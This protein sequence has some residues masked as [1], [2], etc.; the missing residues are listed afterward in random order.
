MRLQIA[1]WMAILLFWTTP[2]LADGRGAA[3]LSVFSSNDGLT[4]VSPQA[5][6][7]AEIRDWLSADANYEADIISAASVDLITAASPRGYREERHG[8]GAGVTIRPAEA[9]VLSVHYGPSFEPDYVSHGASVSAEREWFDRRLTTQI[10]YRFSI[11]RIGRRG[12]A[13]STWRDLQNHSLAASLGWVFSRR[14]VGSLV[15]EAQFHDGFQASPYRFVRLFRAGYPQPVSIPEA[16]PDQRIR[17]AF[18]MGLRRAFSS[19][20]FG[21][22]HLRL[23]TDSWGISSFTSEAEV[24]RT[25]WG[26]RLTLGVR[27]RVYEQSSATFHAFRYD[28]SSNGLRKWRDADKML[29]SSFSFLGGPRIELRL[30]PAG[31]ISEVMASC[32]IDFYTQ[33]FFNFAY[34]TERQATM[35]AFGLTAEFDP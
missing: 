23:Y 14:M 13:A 2:A 18:A 27:G 8:F 35:T 21:N 17:H 19:Q 26:S 29:S 10:E 24:Q 32:S 20:W 11:D 4:V 1:I 9:T 28:W 30:G 3:W 16:V 7:R 34:L 31:P 33:H 22:L 12:D 25:F 5:A 15:Y 6:A